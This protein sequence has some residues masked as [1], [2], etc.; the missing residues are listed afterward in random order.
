VEKGGLSNQILFQNNWLRY[1]RQPKIA[2]GVNKT[3]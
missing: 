2:P 3:G 1:S